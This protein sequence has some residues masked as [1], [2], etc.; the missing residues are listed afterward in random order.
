MQLSRILSG[1]LL[2]AG[3]VAAAR[4][5]RAYDRRARHQELESARDGHAP[6]R[7]VVVGCG[8][9]GLAAVNHLTELVGDD[10]R[11][12]ILLVDR[13]NYHLFYPLL[14][15]VATGGIEAGTLAYPIRLVARRRGFRYLEANVEKVDLAAN[16]LETDAGP[17]EYDRL[18]LAPGSTSNF[19]GMEDA[20]EHAIPLKSLHNAMHLRDRI[21]ETFELAD[22]EPD[23]ERRR[24]LL[25]YVLVGGGATGVELAS[26]LSDFIYGSLLPNYPGIRP[27]EV[28]LV[29][30]E[31]NRTVLNG[32]T[33]AVQQI[34]MRRLR[35]R[36]VRLEL[37]T[38]VAH[39]TDS[40]V[41]TRGGR[42]IPA[43][44][45]VW[46]AGIKAPP[47]IEKLPGSRER[48]GRI[49]VDA[50]LALPGHPEVFVV[51]DAAFYRNP[52]DGK[53]VPP[54]AE[55]ALSEG[56]AAAEN[57]VR[58][59]Q[60]EPTE[61]YRFRSKG[62]LVSLGRG[63]A[64]A[65]IFGLTLDSLPAW[66]VR[67]SVYLVNLVGFRNRLLVM[68]DWIFVSFHRRVISSTEGI[69]VARREIRMLPGP[70]EFR[71]SEEK[72]PART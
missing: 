26:S 23:P 37:G 1:A 7:I 70:S 17:V 5:I 65:H 6:R 72:T 63:A 30:V 42:G 48:D 71:P 67:R 20:A 39:V 27:S 31:S 15:Q 69:T 52:V 34:A 60:G 59:L 22:Q 24:A 21:V 57:A 8:F 46:T 32:W 14:Y 16:R 58:S 4:Q 53:P 49:H 10:P 28:S 55:A 12:D 45:V 51:G 66:F 33:P 62:E 38:T 19:F 44:T 2:L 54:T 13:N 61:T 56:H 3:G 43:A 41:E 47:L 68:I 35:A 9:A 29:M 40:G 50:H 64:A 25:G 36:G 11:Y 18:I